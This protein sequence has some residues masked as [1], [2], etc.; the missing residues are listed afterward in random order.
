VTYDYYY[1]DSWQVQEVRKGGSGNPYEQYVWDIRYVHAPVCRFEDHDTDGN[2]IETLYYTQ[3]ANYNVTA[4]VNTNGTV[5][6]RYVYDPYGKVTIYS[7]D[8]SVE[9]S[10]ANSKQSAVLFTGHRYDSE[11][12]MYYACNRYLHPTLGRWIQRDPAEYVDGLSLYE[13]VGCSPLARRDPLGL[14]WTKPEVLNIACCCAREI[15]DRI[16]KLGLNVFSRTSR[17]YIEITYKVG[18]DGEKKEIDRRPMIEGGYRQGKKIVVAAERSAEQAVALLGHEGYHAEFNQETQQ[19]VARLIK[20]NPGMKREEA[21]RRAAIAHEGNTWVYEE[22]IRMKCNIAEKQKDFR[23]WA[24]APAGYEQLNKQYYE[25]VR[26][27]VTDRYTL[28]LI[29]SNFKTPNV[30][31]IRKV[32]EDTYRDTYGA[33]EGIIVEEQE[34]KPAGPEVPTGEW[35]CP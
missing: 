9:V 19:E 11:T 21:I 1:N 20:A 13:Y 17:E 2:N 28:G 27:T 24:P 26:G 7:S 30:D 33:R 5:A 8:W 23:K 18:A 31:Q 22:K 29:E 15:I 6:E 3:D 34:T 12:G 16:N 14:N 10:W 25:A 35:K 4:L 32:V